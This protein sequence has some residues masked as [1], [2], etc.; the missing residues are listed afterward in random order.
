MRED[1]ET[2]SRGTPRGSVAARVKLAVGAA[3]VVVA[4]VAVVPFA[5]ASVPAVSKAPAR[6]AASAVVAPS[7]QGAFFAPI[8]LWPHWGNPLDGSSSSAAR[9]RTPFSTWP[10]WGGVR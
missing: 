10:H 7:Q 8:P 6:A 1:L 2:H 4:S 9:A 5:A 3:V